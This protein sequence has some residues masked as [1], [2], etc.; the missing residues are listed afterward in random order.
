MAK[1]GDHLI[2]KEVAVTNS[3]IESLPDH[4]KGKNTQ[5]SPQ[6]AALGTF[7]I[8]FPQSLALLDYQRTL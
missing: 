2:S 4:R 5:Y 6:D 8:F 1:I 3:R 7:S